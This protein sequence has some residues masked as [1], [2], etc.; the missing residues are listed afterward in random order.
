[1]GYTIFTT[2]HFI[3]IDIFF[4][5]D[6]LKGFKIQYSSI[7]KRTIAAI[8]RENWVKYSDQRVPQP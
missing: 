6:V 3:C 7:K 4:Q 1:M 8:V 5:I 2:G